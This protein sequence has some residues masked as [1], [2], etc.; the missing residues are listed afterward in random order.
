MYLTD[1][2]VTFKVDDLLKVIY[3]PCM[4]SFQ[5]PN[6]TLEDWLAMSYDHFYL[7]Y[8]FP[9]L[10]VK[11][12]AHRQHLGWRDLHVCTPCCKERL[13]KRKLL[14]QFLDTQKRKPLNTLDLFGGV[15]AFSR[16]L[17]EGSGCLKITHAIE[18]GPSAAK[19]FA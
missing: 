18:I 14:Y 17:A 6:H 2:K 15:G 13:E 4:E 5:P 8:A 10:K 1:E 9:E 7:K 3:V 11:D 12:W 16:G 19:T